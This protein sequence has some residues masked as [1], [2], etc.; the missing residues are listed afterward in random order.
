M[1]KFALVLGLLLSVLPLCLAGCG[2]PETENGTGSS[3]T[4]WW[5][6]TANIE[7]E[8]LSSLPEGQEVLA[9]FR[10]GSDEQKALED[11]TYQLYTL[12]ENINY[13]RYPFTTVKLYYKGVEKP[14]YQA[15]ALYYK[16]GEVQELFSQDDSYYPGQFFPTID[17]FQPRYMYRCYWAFYESTDTDPPQTGIQGT[18]GGKNFITSFVYNLQIYIRDELPENGQ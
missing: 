13:L 14:C 10:A 8:V 18:D 11:T 15:G 16:E 2:D 6:D 1:K 5:K 7:I 3:E 9:R 17:G 12:R 4:P